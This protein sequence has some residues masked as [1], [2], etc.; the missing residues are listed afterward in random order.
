MRRTDAA[1]ML[2]VSA[3]LLTAYAAGGPESVAAAAIALVVTGIL[4]APALTLA[5]E[6]GHA[7]AALALTPRAVAI[8]MGTEPALARFSIGRLAVR[9]SP[10]GYAARCDIA[11][12]MPPPAR[13]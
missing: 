2:A 1:A 7:L 3:G 6:L 10:T 9:L 13:L 4:A 11:G 12:P 8:H 5:H